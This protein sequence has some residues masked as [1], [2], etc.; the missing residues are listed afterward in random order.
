MEFVFFSMRPKLEKSVSAKAGNFHLPCQLHRLGSIRRKLSSP[1]IVGSFLIFFSLHLSR[2]HVNCRSP[3]SCQGM[4]SR[5]FLV[6]S[7][8]EL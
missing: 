4:L 1:V 3:C 7:G 6:L 8:A 2:F 5:Q